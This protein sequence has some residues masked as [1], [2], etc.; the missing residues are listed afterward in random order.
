MKFHDRLEAHF[1]F[2]ALPIVEPPGSG[3][4]VAAQQRY[5]LL[6]EACDVPVTAEFIANQ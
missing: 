3:P 2:R 6:A 4:H 5:R 1:G